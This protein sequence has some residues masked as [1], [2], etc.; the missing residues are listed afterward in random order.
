MNIPNS[1]TVFRIILIP[2]FV[3]VFCLPVKWS[4]LGSAFIFVL[5]AITDWLDGYLARRLNQSTSFGAFLDPVAD[6]LMVLIAL[7]LLVGEQASLWFTLPALV[8]IAREI[9]VSALREW[10][11]EIGKRASVAVSYLGKLK[12]TLQMIAII[13]LLARDP[14]LGG[15]LI[16]LGY[17]MFYASAALTLLSSLL[18]ISAA[19]SDLRASA[20]MPPPPK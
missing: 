4:F 17:I 18:Y 8:I 14:D 19:W 3:L 15:Y 1:L 10:M 9:L 20:T 6:K 16:T 7:V 5:A 11:A 2:V 13:V 12:T